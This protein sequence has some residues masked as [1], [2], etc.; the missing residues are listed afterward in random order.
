[1]KNFASLILLLCAS[2]AL[3]AEPITL[4]THHQLFLDD[5]LIASMNGVKRTVEQ[6]QK[7]PKN[8]LIWPTESWEEKLATTTARLSATATNTAPGT[9]PAWASAMREPRWHPLTKPALD[10]CLI[11]GQKTNLLFHKKPRPKAP[12]DSPI[13]TS[14][15][16]CIAT[17]AIPI[18][19]ATTKWASS[20]STSNTPAARSHSA[21]APRHGV[22]AECI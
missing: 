9:N 7:H 20:T 21:A 4:D 22:A 12:K 6:A 18:P 2:A 3:A 17:S 19:R 15:S 11:D 8:P 10:L 5:Y 16:A 1:M 13:T 14:F